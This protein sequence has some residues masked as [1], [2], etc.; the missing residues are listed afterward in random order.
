MRGTE[1]GSNTDDVGKRPFERTSDRKNYTKGSHHNLS[2]ADNQGAIELAQNLIFVLLHQG[3]DLAKR[4]WA[5]VSKPE[6]NASR[7]ADQTTWRHSF[8]RV[9]ELSGTDQHRSR[10][11]TEL[12]KDRDGRNHRRM[13]RKGR[14]SEGEVMEGG[15]IREAHLLLFFFILLAYPHGFQKRRF[16]SLSIVRSGWYGAAYSVTIFSLSLSA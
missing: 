12:I 14:T 10:G 4:D 15:G 8:R 9:R 13:K 16:G 5:G 6:R 2:Y 3:P 1:N 11:I 7:R